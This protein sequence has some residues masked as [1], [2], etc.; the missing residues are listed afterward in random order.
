MILFRVGGL[1]FSIF[2]LT[3]LSITLI[4]TATAEA[5]DFL[6]P[7]VQLLLDDSDDGAALPFRDCYELVR[8]SES[9][10]PSGV[11]K[12][13]PSGMVTS[14]EVY[15]EM[16]IDG[17]GWTLVI[18]QDSSD[19]W[20]DW[21]YNFDLFASSG[22][23]TPDP[24]SDG[25]FYL[26]HAH[27]VGERSDPADTN[28]TRS[29]FSEQTQYLFASGDIQDWLITRPSALRLDH[30]GIST[31]LPEYANEPQNV[32]IADIDGISPL[33]AAYRWF[34][35]NTNAEDPWVSLG[36]H[37]LTAMSTSIMLYGE[38]GLGIFT[39]RGKQR[40]GMNVFVRR[41]D[42]NIGCTYEATFNAMGDPDVTL[43]ALPGGCSANLPTNATG[44]ETAALRAGRHGASLTF[45]GVT[46]FAVGDPE[47]DSGDGHVDIFEEDPETGALT[48]VQTLSPSMVPALSTFSEFGFSVDMSSG[49]VGNAVEQ[50]LVIGAP[51][52]DS[53]TGGFAIF[54][55]DEVSEDFQYF[56]SYTPVSSSKFR[57][58]H[59]INTDG[60]V[61]LAGAP[62][63]SATTAGAAGSLNLQ[64]ISASVVQFPSVPS[65]TIGQLG[66]GA[67]CGTSVLITGSPRRFLVGCPGSSQIEELDTST[68]QHK[69]SFFI[70]RP[71]Y[72]GM[73]DRFG[74]SLAELT[75][76]SNESVLLIGAPQHDSGRGRLVLA[77]SITIG[78]SILFREFANIE[79]PDAS[80]NAFG[81]DVIAAYPFVTVF[82]A[83]D[84]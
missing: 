52:T 62:A 7:I 28:S 79:S 38:N 19:Q 10:L 36:D 53:D 26:P 6:P 22:T 54:F 13:Q 23:Y 67:E 33:P 73:G 8:A 40:S 2:F 34:F 20:A 12:L 18:H 76:P 50:Y 48:L 32:Q 11:Y 60:V 43:S 44:S 29:E 37:P 4:G 42:P 51:G 30:R 63:D 68:L 72:I 46:R 9:S 21:N 83:R 25:N 41:A 56:S 78:P 57:M 81:T 45:G 82:E 71:N 15:C 5:E 80:T 64:T 61:V 65:P 3:A 39:D 70:P 66:P 69:P 16:T 74:E 14:M 1:T 24:E 35:R 75:L 47:A 58:G 27:F 17:G 77:R 59:S 49:P 31:A 55:F 84:P